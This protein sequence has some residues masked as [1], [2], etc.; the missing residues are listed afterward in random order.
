VSTRQADTRHD[1]LM[2]EPRKDGENTTL[3]QNSIRC[4]LPRPRHAP[5]S[6]SP[7][8]KWRKPI[9]PPRST[10]TK[11]KSPRIDGRIFADELLPGRR[12]CHSRTD[13]LTCVCTIGTFIPAD[14]VTRHICRLG[15][16][17]CLPAN[18]LKAKFGHRPTYRI[19]HRGLSPLPAKFLLNS[20]LSK[21]APLT[22]YITDL[23][24][25]FNS[26]SE[27]VM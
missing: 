8:I 14:R 5:T 27:S 10:T 11:Y 1:L 19:V 12:L 25:S 24:S 15:E 3:H 26:A 23:V 7:E 4:I 9:C 6:S 17:R 18:T 20:F 13:T 2:T 21:L 16:T 22:N